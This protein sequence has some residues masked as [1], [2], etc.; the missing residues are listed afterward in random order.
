MLAEEN[1]KSSDVRFLVV[2]LLD[3]DNHEQLTPHLGRIQQ[4]LEK[5]ENFIGVRLTWLAW[6]AVHRLAHG[7]VLALARARDRMLERL[8]LNGWRRLD[9]PASC[10][11][12][13]LSSERAACAIHHVH[14][15]PCKVDLDGRS[16]VG[17][18]IVWT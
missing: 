12:G 15:P 18:G 10:I 7:D 6:E 9:R 4:Q 2:N 17:H 11:S 3:G 1:L 8:Y 13:R 5:H 14:T 16:Y